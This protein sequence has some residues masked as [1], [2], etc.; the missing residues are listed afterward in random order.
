MENEILNTRKLNTIDS[1]NRVF[2]HNFKYSLEPSVEIIE[3]DDSIFRD[4]YYEKHFEEIERLGKGSYGTVFKVVYD[5]HDYAVKKIEFDKRQK[6]RIL[7]EE[8]TF[9]AVHRLKRQFVVHHYF[10]WLENDKIENKIVLYMRM[11]LCDKTLKEVMNEINKDPKMKLNQI[12]TPMGYFIASRL[13][14]EILEGVQYL[15]ENKIIHRD[16]NPFNIMLII[17][18]IHERIVRICDFNLIAIHKYASQPHSSQRGNISYIAPEVENGRNYDT[19]SDLYSLGV[20]LDELFLD[21][22]GY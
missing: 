18:S 2:A 17:D 3:F 1:F 12:L 21:K 13:Y 19:K 16:L 9:F 10:S 20:I 4:G 15:H 11:E 8:R 14:I 22:N 7:R 6:D 5:M